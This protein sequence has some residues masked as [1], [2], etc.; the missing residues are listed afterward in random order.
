MAL[1]GCDRRPCSHSLALPDA[2]GPGVAPL[3]RAGRAHCGGR[4]G[5][6]PAAGPAGKRRRCRGPRPGDRREHCAGGE[7][8]RFSGLVGDSVPEQEL[9]AGAFHRHR[10]RAESPDRGHQ[11]CGLLLDEDHRASRSDH[12]GRP[13]RSAGHARFREVA[14]YID[15]CRLL[16]LLWPSGFDVAVLPRDVRRERFLESALPCRKNHSSIGHDRAGTLPLLVLC[17]HGPREL[18][19]PWRALP[20]RPAG[21]G[22]EHL[23]LPQPPRGDGL[24]DE[25]AQLGRHADLGWVLR[26]A[27]RAQ[28]VSHA[29]H[30][31]LPA[32]DAGQVAGGQHLARE[33]GAIHRGFRG[34]VC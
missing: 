5:A 21:Q 10:Y 6:A 14:L 22:V 25:R 30:W 11:C 29:V 17:G 33:R 28:R 23:H 34:T 16:R 19:D 24:L 4:G 1:H 9:Q 8:E 12:P 20:E 31:I 2:S 27:H 26:P 3:A 15:R 7:V 18:A 32:R 13:V